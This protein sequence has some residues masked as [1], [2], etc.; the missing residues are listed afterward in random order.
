MSLAHLPQTRQILIATR[1]M[2]QFRDQQV[3]L[4]KSKQQFESLLE[5]SPI[6]ALISD[7]EGKIHRLNRAFVQLF[8]YTHDSYNFV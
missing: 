1:D 7:N 6:P 8:G 4:M 5:F 2:T 3:A